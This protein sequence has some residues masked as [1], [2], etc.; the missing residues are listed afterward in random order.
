MFSAAGSSFGPVILVAGIGAALLMAYLT[1]IRIMSLVRASDWSPESDR[2][3]PAEL[4]RHA[5]WGLIGGAAA[6]L[7]SLNA[8]RHGET[9][10]LQVAVL[11]MALAAVL[12]GV[13]RIYAGVPGR[14]HLGITL[15]ALLVFG[16]YLGVWGM[17][18]LVATT[19]PAGPRTPAIDERGLDKR[20]RGDFGGET[21]GAPGDPVT[22]QIK[23]E[24]KAATGQPNNRGETPPEQAAGAKQGQGNGVQDVRIEGS[25][26]GDLTGQ[27]ILEYQQI[28][29]PDDLSRNL[30]GQIR[31]RMK[32]FDPDT[33]AV[34]Y[35]GRVLGLVRLS[36]VGE[37]LVGLDGANPDTFGRH[38]ELAGYLPPAGTEQGT[39]GTAFP[40]TLRGRYVTELR[41]DRFA[42]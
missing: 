22:L 18:A 16:T 40:I 41:L 24:I 1:G 28:T 17:K 35:Q 21:A 26:T 32:I 31:G 3:M 23:G 19:S 38:M 37:I 42:R 7:T 4:R 6:F 10:I 11:V 5:L 12:S 8:F 13:M 2:P 34:L 36:G 33:G 14:W 30:S 15:A 29:L 25:V 27:V 9:G 39:T 20:D